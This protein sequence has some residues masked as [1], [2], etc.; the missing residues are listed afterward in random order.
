MPADDIS[1]TVFSFH[2]LGKF[3]V[4]SDLFFIDV[5]FKII[6]LEV[7]DVQDDDVS[8]IL[9]FQMAFDFIAVSE[10][11][12]INPFVPGVIK[13]V[14]KPFIHFFLHLLMQTLHLFERVILTGKEVIVKKTVQEMQA[15]FLFPL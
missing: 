6:F 11:T 12:V 9:L 8:I 10:K 3:T 14:A 1:L 4:D 2:A 7:R 13:P 5:D 15:V